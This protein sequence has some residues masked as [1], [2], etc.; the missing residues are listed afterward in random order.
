MNKP[1]RDSSVSVENGRFTTTCSEPE[2]LLPQT[3]IILI[4]RFFYNKLLHPLV[5]SITPCIP[6]TN[7]IENIALRE[8]FAAGTLK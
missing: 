8:K 5:S 1:S 7:T 3:V 2:F 6:I 4:E